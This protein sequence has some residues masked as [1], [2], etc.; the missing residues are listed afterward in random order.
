MAE[1]RT[2]PLS[3]ALTI[4]VWKSRARSRRLFSP[5]EAACSG[6]SISPLAW[7]T[8]ALLIAV[9]TSSSDTPAAAT[10]S[11]FTATR[12][13]GWSAPPTCTCA[14]PSTCDRRCA[15]PLSATS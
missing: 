6:P 15:T 10:A 5:I 14:T 11:G 12:T 3:V 7:V 2:T 1:S 4:S 8:L 9:R 13:A